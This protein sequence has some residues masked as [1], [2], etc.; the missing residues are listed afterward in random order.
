VPGAGAGR[1]YGGRVTATRLT[2]IVFDCRWPAGPA[3]S[4]AAG[5]GHRVAPYTDEDLARLASI[6]R[7]PQSDPE[8]CGEPRK[9]GAG[10]TMFLP[11]RR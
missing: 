6:G 1:H 10:P 9:A 11:A 4:W 3:R 8:V 5:L 2:D 7:A